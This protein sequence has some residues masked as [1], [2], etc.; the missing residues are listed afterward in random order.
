[1]NIIL[2]YEEIKLALTE[3]VK[4]QGFPTKN[5]KVTVDIASDGRKSHSYHAHI[6]IEHPEL[7]TV[8][9]LTEPL[10]P[11]LDDDLAVDFDSS[12]KPLI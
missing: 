8:T 9:H 3:Y 11:M 6:V 2:Q 12:D 10:D 1:M 4:N 7:G 5:R